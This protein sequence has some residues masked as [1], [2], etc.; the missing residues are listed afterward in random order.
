LNLSDNENVKDD[1]LKYAAELHCHNTISDIINTPLP[2]L[3]EIT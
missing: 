3:E 1:F 2:P